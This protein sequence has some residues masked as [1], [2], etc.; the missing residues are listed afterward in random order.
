MSTFGTRLREARERA[1]MTQAELAHAVG[2]SGRGAVN[3]WENDKQ[4]PPLEAVKLLAEALNVS[5]GWLAFGEERTMRKWQVVEVVDGTRMRVVDSADSQE[6]AQKLRDVAEREEPCE[7]P[8]ACD[9]RY[10]VLEAVGFPVASEP[11]PTIIRFDRYGLDT[12]IERLNDQDGLRIALRSGVRGMTEATVRSHPIAVLL[13]FQQPADLID[14]ARDCLTL[15][16]EGYEAMG[17]IR[18]PQSLR[19]V[20]DQWPIAARNHPQTDEPARSLSSM[21]AGSPLCP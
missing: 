13:T 11:P 7:Q 2:Y 20:I 3:G 9:V 16:A 15:A 12:Y 8:A 19:Q 1:G 4:A 10:E 21:A 14:L 6:E 5:A 17:E 18:I